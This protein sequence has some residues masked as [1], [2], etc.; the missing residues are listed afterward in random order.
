MDINNFQ[1]QTISTKLSSGGIVG[2]CVVTIMAIIAMCLS[3]V[4]IIGEGKKGPN[5][6]RGE[7]G[8]DGAEISFTQATASGGHVDITPDN[9]E[10]TINMLYDTVTIVGNTNDLSWNTSTGEFSCVRPGTFQI[11]P[12]AVV[13][14]TPDNTNI[15]MVIN[16]YITLF[17]KGVNS[18]SYDVTNV[19]GD[20]KQFDTTL[21]PTIFI[22]LQTGDVVGV[23]VIATLEFPDGGSVPTIHEVYPTIINV[24]RVSDPAS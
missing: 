23:R 2:L 9:V 11:L 6:E 14:I 24:A 1:H 13:S 7:I 20:I 10:N 18:G 12:Q 4:S 21:A 8:E 19:G 22:E 17:Y 16:A 3:V 5:G 15:N